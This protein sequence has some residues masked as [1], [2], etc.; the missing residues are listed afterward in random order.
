[1][2]VTVEP[3]DLP[4]PTKWMKKPLAKHDW[5]VDEQIKYYE[6]REKIQEA[7]DRGGM[8]KMRQRE[9]GKLITPDTELVDDE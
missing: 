4:E 2:M 8:S 6:M 3:K 1:M 9:G 5:T 7:I